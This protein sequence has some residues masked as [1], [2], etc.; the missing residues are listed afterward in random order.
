[1]DGTLE[2]SG[3]LIVAKTTEAARAKGANA[4]TIVRT[5]AA[6][7]GGGGGGKP[8]I[9]QAGLKDASTLAAALAAVPEALVG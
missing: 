2:A 7:V 8:D 3:A 1:M 6:A 9:A 5:I 4:G